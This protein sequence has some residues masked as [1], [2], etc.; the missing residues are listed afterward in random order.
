ME[1]FEGIKYQDQGHLD[2]SALGRHIKKAILAKIP[3]L[4]ISVI[5]EKFS[6]G[7]SIH[8]KLHKAPI[9][10][11]KVITSPEVNI[12]ETQEYKDL[13]VKILDIANQWNRWNKD[14]QSDYFDYSFFVSVYDSANT[15]WGCEVSLNKGEYALGKHFITQ[16]NDTYAG[17]TDWKGDQFLLIISKSGNRT[18]IR[19][20]QAATNE[21]LITIDLAAKVTSLREAIEIVLA[22]ETA[23]FN[24]SVSDEGWEKE[25]LPEYH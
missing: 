11:F 22:K 24:N 19:K 10:R 8:I 17:L 21:T 4:G 25:R 2:I 1:H 5:T 12:I 20:I 13:L 16:A 6:G 15:E 3:N 18:V 14:V 23:D 9:A 7:R